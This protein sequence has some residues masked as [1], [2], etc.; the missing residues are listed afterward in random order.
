MEIIVIELEVNNGYNSNYT[1]AQSDNQR[2]V[3]RKLN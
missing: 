1:I 2:I 3:K